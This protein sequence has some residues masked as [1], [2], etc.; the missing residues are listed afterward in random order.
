[1]QGH[2]ELFLAGPCR[3]RLGLLD[4]GA[5]RQ[6]LGGQINEHRSEDQN[7][8]KPETPIVMREFPVRTM[9]LLG[10]IPIMIGLVVTVIYFVHGLC[11]GE[12]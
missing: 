12:N 8:P 2:T 9:P 3:G 4:P 7:Q 11:G 1:M 5:P 6:V 10:R